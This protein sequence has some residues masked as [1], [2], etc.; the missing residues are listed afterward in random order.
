M[1]KSKVFLGGVCAA[2]VM[3]AAPAPVHAQQATPAQLAALLEQIAQLTQLVILLQAQVLQ[4]QA[5]ESGGATAQQMEPT[6]TAI[7]PDEEIALPVDVY[8]LDSWYVNVR[9]QSTPNEILEIFDGEGGVN[10]RFW[11]QANIRWRVRNVSTHTITN[12]SDYTHNLAAITNN[13]DAVR[14]NIPNLSEG[15]TLQQAFNV[16][17][18]R[19]LETVPLNGMY[20]PESGVAIVSETNGRVSGRDYMAYLFAHELG[21][22]LGLEHEGN[23]YN[24]MHRGR[25]ENKVPRGQRTTLLAQQIADARA[26]AQMGTHSLKNS[27]LE[28]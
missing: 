10:D 25:E 27:Y 5:I 19:S 6:T 26:Q 21:H 13:D 22:A 16:F 11:K 18:I 17:V 23:F 3:A 9:A 20:T 2:V 1:V 14:N 12:G 4:L 28:N 7:G 24:L 15:V 8:L